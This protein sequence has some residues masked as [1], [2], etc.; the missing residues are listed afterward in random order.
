MTMKESYT[1]VL[2]RI[3]E[4]LK[5]FLENN[6]RDHADI[7][8]DVK[9]LKLNVNDENKLICARIKVLEDAKL[10]NDA[11]KK[12]LKTKSSIKISSKQIKVTIASI[13]TA[14]ISILAYLASIGVI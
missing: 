12:V 6:S 3:D 1:S 8:N 9:E 2:A 11:E 5:N 13:A 4:K 14:I 7:R 10:V